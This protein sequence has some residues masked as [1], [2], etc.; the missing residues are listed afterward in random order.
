M[1]KS[2]ELKQS[3]IDIQC[4]IKAMVEQAQEVPA[5]LTA[6]FNAL[7]GEYQDALAEEESRRNKMNISI[8]KEDKMDK[9][10]F[11]ASLKA[12]LLGKQDENFGKFFNT[13][14]GQEGTTPASGGYLVPTELLPIAEL[15][16]VGDDLRAICTVVP[17]STR[18][19]SIP[20][21]N[22]GAQTLTLT[23]FDEN[24]A[25]HEDKAVFG[26]AQYTLA[27]KGAIVPVSRELLMDA[28]A[29]VLSIVGKVF[30]RVY[31][32]DVNTAIT[33]LVETD[34]T[35][36]GT[37]L[38]I[39]AAIDAVKEA[40]ITLPK[41]NAASTIVMPQSTWAEFAKAKDQ[42][43]RYLLAKDTNGATVMEIEGRPVVVIEDGIM[44]A[45]TVLVGDFSAIYHIAHPSL[46]IASSAE[47]GFGRNSVLVRAVCRYTNVD[48]FAA[49]F[50]KLTIA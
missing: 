5:E 46:E 50:K 9:K 44:T 41:A 31:M 10:L 33:T 43:G 34:A 36:V 21:I 11:N 19:G 49:A 38:A 13:P 48:V 1:L 7:K 37:A 47:A 32:Q 42:K 26:T 2:H 12:A 8:I 15:N 30:N 39:D 20:T 25:I 24:D 4:Q 3:M 23:A 28:D 18:S 29:D 14:N 40:V 27:S 22:Y 35:S 45:K 6:E 17:V 16:G